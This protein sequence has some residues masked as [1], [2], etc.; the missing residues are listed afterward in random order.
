MEIG[1]PSSWDFNNEI[2]S[3]SSWN[4]NS[5]IRS[6]SSGDF[7]WKQNYL[8]VEQQRWTAVKNEFNKIGNS[9]KD[10]LTVQWKQN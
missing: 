7:L 1:Y 3:P 6:P 10:K 9:K 4:F 2:R 8:E 5:E